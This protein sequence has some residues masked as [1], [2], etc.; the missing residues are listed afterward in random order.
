MSKT[1]YCIRHGLSLHNKLYHKHGSKTFYDSDY[2]DTML[3]PEGKQQA[4]I[5]GETW[6]E[7]NNIELVIVSPLKRTLETAVNIFEDIDVPIIA[8]EICREFPM[9]LHTCNKRSNKEE[10]E[11]LYPRVNFDNILSNKDDLW[12]DKK[13]ESIDS[14]NSRITLVKKYIKNRPE[15]NIAFVNHAGFIGQMKDRHIKYL[16]N[17]EE[18][19]KHCFPYKML[20]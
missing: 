4:R 18:E 5:L 9:G 16:D 12:N 7:I 8:L 6:D 14:L 15:K 11:L 1:L 10:L 19:L 20:I 13:E 17:G 2:V 3:L